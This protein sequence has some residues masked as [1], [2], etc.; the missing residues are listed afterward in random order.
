MT[1]KGPLDPDTASWEHDS[2]AL[3]RCMVH[4]QQVHTCT[5]NA[6]LV[7][8]HKTG[9]LVC[10]RGTPWTL[11]D[12]NSINEDGCW[13][14][15]QTHS[16]I[17]GYNP[18]ISLSMYCNNDIKLLTNGCDTKDLTWYEMGYQTKKQGRSFNI[19]ALMAKGLLYHMQHSKYILDLQERNWL[20]IFHCTQVLYHETEFSGAQVHL[21]L[22]G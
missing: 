22:M 9:K 13:T 6:C 3:K 12:I 18:Q 14:I 1:R 15:K 17:N 7:Y 20:L 10:K 2:D 4:S 5:R 19:S 16:H 8:H 11:S 21:Y